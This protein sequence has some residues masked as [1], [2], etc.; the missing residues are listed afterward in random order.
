MTTIYIYCY[1][2]R[3]SSFPLKIGQIVE[4]FHVERKGAW[5]PPFE[6]KSQLKKKEKE[7]IAHLLPLFADKKS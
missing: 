1:P 3:E 5:G 2:R 7:E 4:I 6:L